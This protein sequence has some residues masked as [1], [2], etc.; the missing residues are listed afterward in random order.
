[1]KS[2]FPGMDPYLEAH[3]GD[4]HTR[5]IVYAS[6]QLQ[7]Q[8]PEELWVRVEEHVGV[9][10][11]DQPERKVVPDIRVVGKD[12]EELRQASNG[13][14]SVAVA[15][16]LVVPLNI[17]PQTERWIEVIDTKSGE[18]VVTAIEIL[19]PANKSTRSGR[20]A[21]QRK[22]AEFLEAGINLVEIDLLREGEYVL[23]MPPQAVP[24]DYRAPYRIAV[25]RAH[26]A[27]QGE[28]YRVPLK[29]RLPII[30]IPL[31]PADAD[32]LLDVQAMID[33]AYASG[34]FR[35]ISYRSE[36]VPSLGSEDAAWA[37]KLLRA[38]RLR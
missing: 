6:E 2:P 38:E 35:R 9:L 27:P 13:A 18:R 26:Q 33:R 16:P 5:L 3:W 21:Y 36:P 19:S 11:E 32:A 10:L 8:M 29:E 34:G 23:A 20:E 4:V 31:R 22:Q 28:L 37:D 30:R 12:A 15:E 17:E 24:I 1:M 25:V 7:P 14:S